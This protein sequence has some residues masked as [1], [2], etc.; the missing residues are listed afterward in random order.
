MADPILKPVSG[1][2]PAAAL[3]GAELVPVL[4]GGVSKRAT[5]Q[6]IANLGGATSQRTAHI[7][8]SSCQSVWTNQPSGLSVFLNSTANTPEQS[9]VYVSLSQYL[10]CRL[11][12]FVAVAGASGSRLIIRYGAAYNPNASNYLDMSA[13]PVAASIAAVGVSNSGWLPLVVGA[14]ADVIISLMGD[15][16]D[17]TLDPRVYGVVAEFR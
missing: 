1:M 12:A 10:E 3:T 13:T 15:G 6:A 17:A 11:T 5:A 7:V 8:L 16:G 9:N 2:T 14:R 4:Q